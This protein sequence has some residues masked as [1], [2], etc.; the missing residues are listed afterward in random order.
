MAYDPSALCP[1]W[2]QALKSWLDDDELI[3]YLGK[4][5]AASLRGL[6]IVKMIA[7]LLGPGNSGKSPRSWR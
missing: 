1:T 3:T 2:E 7:L 5:L 4:L 6:T